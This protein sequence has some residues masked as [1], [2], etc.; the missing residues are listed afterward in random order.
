MLFGRRRYRKDNYLYLIGEGEDAALI[1]PGDPVVALELAREHGVRPRFILHTH[2]HADH[3]GG[4]AFLREELKAQVF[5]HAGDASFFEPDV[6]LAETSHIA[7][8]ALELGIVQSPGHTP[9]S[10]LFVFGGR[11]MTGDTLFWCGAGNCRHGGDPA[12]LA[13]SLLGPVSQ[14]DHELLVHPGHDYAAVNA[15]FA[16][17]LE[18]DNRE[19]SER[20]DAVVSAANRGEEP[21]PTTLALERQVNPFLKVDVPAVR[22]A[23]V[24]R[25]PSAQNARARLVALRGIRD[26]C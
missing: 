11:L 8:G 23:I 15:R 24:S 6:D 2:G 16:L 17:F 25:V 19:V 7:L 20:L 3:S 13:S 14:L 10:L 26:A 12:A 22:D 5:G 18:P 21:E 4:S 9:G 1:D